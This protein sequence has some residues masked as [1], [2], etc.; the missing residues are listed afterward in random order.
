MFRS[1]EGNRTQN[2]SRETLF[3]IKKFYFTM[4]NTCQGYPDKIKENKF[5]FRHFWQSLPGVDRANCCSVSE[6]AFGGI[7]SRRREGKEISSSKNRAKF[8][9]PGGGIRSGAGKN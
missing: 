5:I 4:Q 6:C 2:V 1:K 3:D 9:V 7:V 8:G